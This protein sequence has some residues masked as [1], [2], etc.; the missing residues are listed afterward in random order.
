MNIWNNEGYDEFINQ[1]IWT[2]N[3]LQSG[4]IRMFLFAESK[5]TG[6]QMW[7]EEKALQQFLYIRT[8]EELEKE[9][10]PDGIEKFRCGLFLQGERIQ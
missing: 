2:K 9:I 10:Y 4:G 6:K 1:R 5:S 3:L 7:S 8:P